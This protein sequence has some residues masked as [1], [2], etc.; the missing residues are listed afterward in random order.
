MMSS[1]SSSSNSS[2]SSSSSSASNQQLS[3]SGNKAAKNSFDL[4]NKVEKIHHG[5]F[6]ASLD[7]LE[8]SFESSSRPVTGEKNKQLVNVNFTGPDPVKLMEVEIR[9]GADTIFK[10]IEG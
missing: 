9:F 6:Q 7:S 3:N 1:N 10:E 2:S 4:A 5:L 8:E